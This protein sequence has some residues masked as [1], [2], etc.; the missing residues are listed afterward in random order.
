VEDLGKVPVGEEVTPPGISPFDHGAPPS[1]EI[2]KA[3]LEKQA[4]AQ[5]LLDEQRKLPEGAALELDQA[6]AEQLE[7]L[8]HE[9]WGRRAGYLPQFWK[10]P[11]GYRKGR[12][13][14]VAP[15]PNPKHWIYAGAL[16]HHRWPIGREMTKA[17]FDAAVAK[18]HDFSI[19]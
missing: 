11:A 12:L 2:T 4:A 6:V 14:A 5:A 13:R 15:T 7:K 3:A 10:N 18:A 17:E 16:A 19:T 8:P 9:E 1:V